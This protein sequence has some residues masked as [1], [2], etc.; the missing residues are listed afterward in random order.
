[1]DDPGLQ[2]VTVDVKLKRGVWITGKVTDKVTGKPV[3]SWIRYGVFEDNPNRRGAPGLT[4]E[5]DMKT[6]PEDATFRFVGLP[7]HGVVTAQ[8]WAGRYLRGIGGDRLKRLAPPFVGQ[9]YFNTAVEISPEKGAEAVT[10]DL[11]LDPG[12]T[13]SGTVAGPDG[14]PLAGAMAAGLSVAGDW[15]HQ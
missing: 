11:A 2:P 6:R 1:P 13:L 5:H 3:P 8:G 14:K 9:G 7:G 4:F 10:C 12:R 15:E